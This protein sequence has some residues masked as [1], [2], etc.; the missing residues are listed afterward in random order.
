MF[1]L[2]SK[3]FYKG[4]IVAVITALMTFLIEALQ[5]ES[6]IDLDL[7]KRLGVA[8]IIGMLSYLLKNLFTNSKDQ[9]MTK[10]K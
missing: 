7:L 5:K 10:E 3:D 6:P 1:N 8:A 9:F 2:G 4:L